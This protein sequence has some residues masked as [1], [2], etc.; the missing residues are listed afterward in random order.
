MVRNTIKSTQ[1]V[2]MTNTPRSPKALA[3]T[4]IQNLWDISEIGQGTSLPTLSKRSSGPPGAKQHE[5]QGKFR[6]QS[7]CTAGTREV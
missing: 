4:P 1:M 5:P 7:V 2:R 3:Q 6:L